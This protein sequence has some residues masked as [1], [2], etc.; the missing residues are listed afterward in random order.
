VIRH[1]LAIDEPGYYQLRAAAVDGQGNSVRYVRYVYVFSRQY[2]NWHG[3]G[4]TLSISADKASYVPGDTA[5]LLIESVLSGPALLTFERGR[6]RREMLVELTAPV[7]MVEVPILPEDVP[8]IH[9]TVNIWQE[10]D[11]QVTEDTYWSLP[12]GRLHRASVNLSVPADDKR[13]S[14]LL[15]PDKAAYSPREEA[16]FTVRVTDRRGEPV[17]AEVSL[18]LVDESIFALSEELAGPIFDAFYYSRD[19]I[20]RTYDALA[21]TRFLTG[22]GGRGGGGGGDGL[23]TNPRQ[24]FPDTAAWLPVLQTDAN[25]EVVV[26]LALPDS[27]TSWRL[28]AKAVTADTRVG[29]AYVNV[30]TRQ[31]VVV[32]PIL[33]RALTAGDRVELVGIVHNYDPISID[34]AVSI[35]EQDQA[36]LEIADPI[37]QVISLAPGEHRGRCAAA[38]P[39]PTAG[40]TRRRRQ[41]GRVSWTADHPPPGA[42]GGASDERRTPRAQPLDRRDVAGGTGV[43]DRLSLRLRRAD[44]EQ[45]VAQCHGWARI[46]PAR[47]RRSGDA[48]GSA[49][50]DQR[51]PAKTV[52]VPAQRWRLGVVV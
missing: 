40:H 19:N 25:G 18:A 22:G 47:G 28:T 16:T 33:P 42:R 12:E 30:L 13:L 9:V 49:A 5:R 6:T 52:R 36:L 39:H 34:V 48:G 17:A 11:T 43:P 15:M 46:S 44:D 21:L 4:S 3:R 35:S 2:A 31:P 45:S 41:G 27:L 26:T 20:V 7:T 50:Q 1:S 24:D 14:V 37:T 51:R 32:R 8:N 29:E 38:N 23:A 10:A